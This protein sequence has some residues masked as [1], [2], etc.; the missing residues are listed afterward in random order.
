MELDGYFEAIY[1]TDTAELQQCG[2]GHA[3]K[4]RLIQ[5]LMAKLG[6]TKESAAFFE[7]TQANLTPA[8]G[9]CGCHLVGRGGIDAA[10]M[11]AIIGQYYSGPDVF[12]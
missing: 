5:K 11:D 12:D 4:S 6:L 2:G 8:E 10:L 1:G 9:I 3:D 7:D